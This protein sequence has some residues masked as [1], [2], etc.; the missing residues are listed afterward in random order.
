MAA[1][2]NISEFDFIQEFT[3]LRGDKQG[4]ALKNK[5]NGECI[6]LSG[7]DCRV[8]TVK[9]K[10]CQDFPNLWNFPGFDKICQAKARI[11]NELE[12]RQLTKSS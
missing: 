4:L 12:W 8:Q 11:V 6:F 3:E 10:Q 2:F 1:F 7:N 9:P 5:A